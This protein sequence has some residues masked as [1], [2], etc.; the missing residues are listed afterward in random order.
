MEL[1]L[2]LA[3]A[4]FLIVVVLTLLFLSVRV[5]RQGYMMVVYRLGEAKA[6]WIREP[7]LRFLVPFI[8][9]GKVVDIRRSEERRVG[10]ECRL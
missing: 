10:K 5:V 2:A 3:V 6:E 1:T 8:W 7:G 9:S 4:A